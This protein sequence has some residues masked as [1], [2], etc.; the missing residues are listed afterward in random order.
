MPEP[1]LTYHHT[2]FSSN[3]EQPKQR[4]LAHAL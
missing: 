4:L 1:M 2:D 3:G